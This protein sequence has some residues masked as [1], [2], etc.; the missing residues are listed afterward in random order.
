M[1]S[2]LTFD[3]IGQESLLTDMLELWLEIQGFYRAL[4]KPKIQ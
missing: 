4:V 1:C 2:V 3:V